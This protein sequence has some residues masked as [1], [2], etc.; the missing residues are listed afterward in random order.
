MND[1]HTGDRTRQ[2]SQDIVDSLV[3]DLR[4]A[5]ARDRA[6]AD[7]PSHL[8]LRNALQDGEVLKAADGRE[9]DLEDIARANPTNLTFQADVVTDPLSAPGDGLP[10]CVYYDVEHP[11]SNTW[12]V[13]RTVTQWR[14]GCPGP[15]TN[16]IDRADLVGPVDVART[17]LAAPSASDPLFRYRYY[18]RQPGGGCPYARSANPNAQQRNGIVEV[19]VPSFVTRDSQGVSVGENESR[20]SVAIASRQ[21]DDY[22]NAIGCR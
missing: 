19:T 17:G 13:V 18:D 15:P 8:I 20:M 12:T 22:R 9:L 16:V 5:R 7:A 14:S 6:G 10:E 2:M 3:V 1:A 4:N 21:A 11:T